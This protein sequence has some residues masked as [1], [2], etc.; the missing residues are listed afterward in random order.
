MTVTEPAVGPGV[1]HLST[2]EPVRP[3]GPLPSQQTVQVWPERGED[4]QV[5]IF[6]GN[7]RTRIPLLELGHADEDAEWLANW[8]HELAGAVASVDR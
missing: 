6:A 3:C 2:S 8:L 5:R 1:V 4:G 7:A